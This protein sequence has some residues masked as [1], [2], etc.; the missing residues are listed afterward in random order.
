MVAKIGRSSPC[1]DLRA[2]ERGERNA[3]AAYRK[4][5]RPIAPLTDP[6]LEATDRY[7]LASGLLAFLTLFG[8]I[9]WLFSLWPSV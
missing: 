3:A 1:I 6:I 9:G 5:L 4:F 2:L 8:F 7:K